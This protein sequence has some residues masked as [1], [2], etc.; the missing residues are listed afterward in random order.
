ML[1]PAKPNFLIIGSAK[2]GTT[3]LSSL[4]SLHPDCCMSRPKEVSFFQ[5]NID[6]ALNPNY[7]KG[8]DWYQQAFKHY[9]GEPIVGEATPS[10]S[11]RSRSPNTARRIYEFNPDMKIIYMVR[12]PLQ[13]QISC[14]K[15]QYALGIEGSCPWRREHQWAVKGFDYWMCMQRDAGQWDECRYHYQLSAYQSFFAS[16]KI[17]VSFLEDWKSH[18]EAEVERIMQFLG[19]DPKL[20]NKDIQEKANRG[21]DRKIDRPMLRR[22]LSQPPVQRMVKQFPLSWRDWARKNWAKIS[23]ATPEPIVS[24][25]VKAAF[26]AYVSTDSEKFLAQ[27]GKTASLWA[28]PLVSSIGTTKPTSM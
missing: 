13:R 1:N 18:K 14:W 10:Y 11:D 8:W 28:R 21:T 12:D 3:A 15:M 9:D 27:Y 16:D 19:L 7:A 17:C 6:F 5:D 20:W 25:A 22:F 24:E 2:C 26:L 23:V 4:L